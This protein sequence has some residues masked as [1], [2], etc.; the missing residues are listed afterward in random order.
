MYWL[1]DIVLMMFSISSSTRYGSAA[2]ASRSRSRFFASRTTFGGSRS[3]HVRLYMFANVGPDAYLG[4]LLMPCGALASL[5]SLMSYDSSI[6]ET[7]QLGQYSGLCEVFNV[8]CGAG[9]RAFI[10]VLL[11]R[12]CLD[13]GKFK[14]VS[15]IS[16][17]S[18]KRNKSRGHCHIQD[19]TRNMTFAMLREC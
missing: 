16:Q 10:A 14:Q 8:I 6:A 7:N 1:C 5:A 15:C 19:Q 17:N 2:M 18:L 11:G 12:Y 9:I 4:L 3:S 13:T